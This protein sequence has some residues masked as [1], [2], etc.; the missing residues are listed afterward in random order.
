MDFLKRINPFKLSLGL[1]MVL[2]TILGI[3]TGLF[4]GESC[5][6]FTSWSS[7][8][9][10]VLKI[11]AIPYLVC[12]II[13]GV[14]QLTGGAAKEILKKGILF[15]ALAW[16]INLVIIYSIS[17]LFPK[18]LGL[19]GNTYLTTE[20]PAINFA[21]LLIP[22]NIFHALANN[23][24]PAIVVFSL[25]IGLSLMQIKEKQTLISLL[26]IALAAL[27]RITSWISR[28][29]PIGTF[30]IISNQVGTIELST[31]K[32][33]STYII[34]YIFAACLLVFWIFPRLVSV[35]TS[36]PPM[37][38]IKDLSPILLLAYTTNMVIVA[39]P[40]IIELIKKEVLLIYPNEDKSSSQVQGIVSIVFNIPLGSLF[41]ILFVLF[42]SLFFQV[43]L[44][45]L[46][47]IE[48]F[49]TTILTSLGAIGIG[50]WLN[51]LT[52]LL[53]L[54]GLPLDTR[55]LYL[56]SV[57]FTAG[58]QAM[59]SA[60]EVTSISL[61]IT[62]ACRRMIRFQW[63]KLVQSCALTLLP[64]AALFVGLKQLH[65]F[66]DIRSSAKSISEVSISSQLPM[67]IYAANALP[68]LLA[69]EDPLDRI[70]KTKILRV[71]YYPHAIPFCFYNDRKELVGYDV[72]FA[73]ELAKDLGCRL[74]FVPLNYGKISD[75]LNANLY[76]IAMSA[77]PMTET[78]L[79]TL[80][81]SEPYLEARFV[82]ITKD[83]R[84]K[85]FASYD[86]VR[87]NKNLK[88]AVLKNSSLEA[89]ARA[90][91]PTQEIVTL[92]SD[93]DFESQN[94]ADAL[95]WTEQSGISWI[96]NN[97]LYTVVFPNPSIGT[98]TLGYA[99]KANAPRFL[100][101]LNQWLKLKKNEG[102]TKNQYELWILGKTE[103]IE[104]RE[105]RWSIVRDVLHWQD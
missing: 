104:E 3:L 5:A 14:G 12:A 66:P 71:G 94:A 86:L 20:T 82:F 87:A 21:Q 98:E 7:A 11:T 1:Q 8:Y 25:C 47:H 19:H 30:I 17:F 83:K 9:I 69:D 65:L 46:Q 76:D 64:L 26:D 59:I 72:S 105:P 100:H 89:A 13:Q 56:T 103:Q 44:H 95:L 52:F 50:S 2:A 22:E 51:V 60:I 70:L 77:V 101:F 57:P 53:D 42:S 4:F 91:F 92:E 39:L 99:T 75:E 29:T 6:V 74:E 36:L 15:I 81:F 32:Q 85:E 93:R 31:I 45:P 79:T 33:M 96:L 62:L 67:T 28:I 34:L 88:I 61:F 10:M 73:L 38:W 102:F 68:P 18:A 54:L 35:L 24:L 63:R 90:L 80:N 37:K 16:L 78:K 41:I 55:E 97:P 23:Y 40:F 27:T 43:P 84:R 48:L 49:L 58:F